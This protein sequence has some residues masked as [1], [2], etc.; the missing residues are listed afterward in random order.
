MAQDRFDT[1]VGNNVEL[2][3]NLSNQGSIEIHGM[4]E[5]EVKSEAD[6]LIGETANV[7]GPV[8][9]KNIEVSGKV[10]GSIEA[11]EKLELR[12]SCQIEGNISAA[13]LSIQPG[14][15]FNGT[16]NMAKESDSVRTEKKPQLEVED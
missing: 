8:Q 2:K 15:T 4:I 1:I 7:I 11:I 16:C 3:G 5:G 13:I 12:S 10:F 6:I 9:A 14:A